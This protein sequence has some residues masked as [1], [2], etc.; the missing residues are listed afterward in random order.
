MVPSHILVR[1]AER[2]GLYS[3]HNH[4]ADLAKGDLVVVELGPHGDFKDRFTVGEVMDVD[5]LDKEKVKATKR[6]VCR[7]DIEPYNALESLAPLPKPKVKPSSGVAA[8]LAA[9][10]KAQLSV[11]AQQS[12]ADADRQAF[13]D[14]MTRHEGETK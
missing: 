7:V 10:Q 11:A 14:E 1:F 12:Q 2:G 3:Y 8:G 13:E 6:I 5:P 9:Y 4:V